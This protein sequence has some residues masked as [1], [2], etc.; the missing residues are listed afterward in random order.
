MVGYLGFCQLFKSI[1]VQFG[2]V[3][4]DLL[5]FPDPPFQ[6]DIL[7]WWLGTDHWFPCGKLDIF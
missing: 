1:V 3:P 7:S 6:I 5:V 4:S 2:S